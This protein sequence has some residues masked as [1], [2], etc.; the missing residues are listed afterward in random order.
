MKKLL[1]APFLFLI[2]VY[3]V[4][5]SPLTP[6]TCRFQPT[7]SHY[8]VKALKKHGLFKGSWLAIKRISRCH[9]WGGSGY[10]PVP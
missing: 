8:I 6:A 3:Q 1:I 5:I 2:K 7:C 10:D 9:P 4:F